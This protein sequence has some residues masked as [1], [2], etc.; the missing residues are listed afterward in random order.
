MA[1]AEITEDYYAIL[2]VSHTASSDTIRRSYRRLAVL[3]HP[4]KNPNTP[5]A[6]AS[7]QLLLRAYE[8]TS[9]PAQRKI[10]DFKWENIRSRA[11]A[12]REAKKR[13][14]EAAE[15]ERKENLNRQREQK[16]RQGRLEQLY[17]EKFRLD[18]DI[19]EVKRVVTRLTTELKRLQEQDDEEE[20]KARA[21]DSWWKFVTSP[22]YGK[23]KESD[24]EKQRREFDRLQRLTSQRVKGF[25][26]D[27]KGARLK[28]L[29]SSLQDVEKKIAAEKRKTED[30]A[31]AQEY[32][33]QEQLRQEQ[34]VRRRQEEQRAREIRAAWERAEAERQRQDT[35]RAEEAAR[36]MR[37]AREERARK[38]KEQEAREEIERR[39]RAEEAAR[40]RREQQTQEYKERCERKDAV[41]KAEAARAA[42]LKHRSRS[43][44]QKPKPTSNFPK[45]EPCQHRAFWPKL[46]GSYTCSECGE[47]QR[48]F[49]F[50]CPGC[51]MIACANCRQE[52]RGQT[53]KSHTSSKRPPPHRQTFSEYEWD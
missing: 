32:Q 16:A 53:T 29:T 47:V 38:Q 51:E 18:R 43:G 24:E 30:E 28:E 17:Q 21:N 31:R 42:R 34:E 39:E 48:R 36:K 37:E 19:F 44:T 46:E 40:K 4:D 13:A 23:T 50:Q 6:T 15:T 33:R 49:V 35:Q 7:F 45:Q 11:N 3:L 12:Q 2:E 52:L 41:R 27:L 14:E 8:T 26:L 22:I 20:R 1:P 9:D 5:N 25:D 10:Y